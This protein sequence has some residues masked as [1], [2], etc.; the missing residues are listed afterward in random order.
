MEDK[1]DCKYRCQYQNSIRC[2]VNAMKYNKNIKP[3]SLHCE[4]CSNYTP[5]D[6]FTK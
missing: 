2:H 5:R 4:N 1:S 6:G 3:I